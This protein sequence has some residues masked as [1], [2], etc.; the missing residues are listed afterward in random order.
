MTA[1][2]APTK[3]YIMDSLRM[4]PHFISR[5]LLSAFF[6]IP[7]TAEVGWSS[8][9][10]QSLD[11]NAFWDYFLLFTKLILFGLTY[12]K[13]V[14][15]LIG[16]GTDDH[17]R[18]HAVQRLV[19]LLP[20]RSTPSTESFGRARI[21]IRL[22]LWQLLYSGSSFL[23]YHYTVTVKTIIYDIKVSSRQV[24]PKSVPMPQSCEP[25]LT[26]KCAIGATP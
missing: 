9:G 3:S 24:A 21:H 22:F 25:R 4:F 20:E 19:T 8:R 10:P 14:Q 15:S 16:K 1:V 12:D 2:V 7:G 17:S 11:S 6:A 13:A 23:F 5:D 18:D 26:K